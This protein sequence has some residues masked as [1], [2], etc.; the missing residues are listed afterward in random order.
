MDLASGQRMMIGLP[1]WYDVI[2]DNWFAGS[3]SVSADAGY[4]WTIPASSPANRWEAV[5]MSCC[6][7]RQ[8][9][10][11]GLVSGYAQGGLWVSLD[12]GVTWS[13]IVIPSVAAMADVHQSVSANDAGTRVAVGTTQQVLLG[14]DS[15]AGQF[16]WRQILVTDA[17]MSAAMNGVGDVVVA[18]VDDR[19]DRPDLVDLRKVLYISVDGGSNWVQRT[20]AAAA[21]SSESLWVQPQWRQVAVSADGYRMATLRGSGEPYLAQGSIYISGNAGRDWVRY[22]LGSPLGG[23]LTMSRDGRYIVAAGG[24]PSGSEF[25]D[26]LWISADAGVT[27][28]QQSRVFSQVFDV[29]CSSNC[30]TLAVLGTA[31]GE[32]SI[33]VHVRYN[34]ST[35]FQRSRNLPGSA[36]CGRSFSPK[37]ILH[38]AVSTC[39][40]CG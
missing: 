5:T 31:L 2:A 28:Q 33:A 21:S 4:T 39:N 35:A 8:F 29:A 34:F 40:A 38:I 24:M 20:P 25:A 9:A 22:D 32:S 19:S 26:T 6:G 36:A 12:A 3:V 17:S 18:W 7:T 13:R 10:L 11:S 30:S 14:E 1:E 37:Q 16:R 27:W 23:C 15:G